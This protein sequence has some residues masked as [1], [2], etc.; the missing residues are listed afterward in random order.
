MNKSPTNLSWKVSIDRGGT[1]TDIVATSSNGEIR[2]GKVLSQDKSGGLAEISGV[3]QLLG[4]EPVDQLQLGTTIGTNAILER[5]G[6]RVGILTN[7][8]LGGIFQV[9][10]QT[11]PDIFSLRYNKSAPIY[12]AI[13]E[14]SA[15]QNVLG[16]W[17]GPLNETEVKG[18]LQKLR[19][20]Q[21]EVLL[22]HFIHSL[23][24]PTLEE[25]VAMIAKDCGFSQVIC[26]HELGV[27]Q[28]LQR[29]QTALVDGYVGP[30]IQSYCQK[31]KE[32]IKSPVYLMQ[33][34]GGLCSIEMFRGKDSL[35]SGPAGGVIG[36]IHEAKRLGIQKIIGFDM[37]GTSTDVFHFSGSIERSFEQEVAGLKLWIPML[38]IHTV[39]SGGG[40]LL[41]YSGERPQ[42]G[43]ESSSSFPGPACYGRGGPLSLTDCS[44]AQGK[45]HPCFFPDVFGDDYNLPLQLDRTNQS[46]DFLKEKV[47]KNQMTTTELAA[48]FA[49]V[50]VEKMALAIEEITTKKGRD[51]KDHTLFCYGG[52]GGQYACEVAER[53]SLNKVAFHPL[54][55]VLSA[56]GIGQA[57]L[58]KETQYNIEGPLSH[59]SNCDVE[60]VF[61]EEKRK[62]TLQFERE[63]IS[64]TINWEFQLRLKYKGSLSI[65]EL[66]Y[67]DLKSLSKQFHKQHQKEFG[68]HSINREIIVDSAIL[69]GIIEGPKL[70]DQN[71]K[72]DL[73]P[74]NQKIPKKISVF[75][76][77]K[78]SEVPVLNYAQIQEKEEVVGP[79]VVVLST[80]S[81][82]IRSGWRGKKQK[83]IFVL[84]RFQSEVQKV[85]VQKELSGLSLE[86]LN[87]RFTSVAKHMG[88]RLQKTAASINI[89]DRLDFSCALFDAI[90]RLIT[91]APHI[92]VHLGS[93]Q[94]SVEAILNKQNQFSPGDCFITNNPYNG[95]THLPDITV[96]SPCFVKG[97]KKPAFFVASRGHHADIGGPVPGSMPAESSSILDEGVLF[98]GE[99]I[100]SGNSFHSDLVRK[101]LGSGAY[102]ARNIEQ[103][104]ADLE[105]QIAA[106]TV[107]IELLQDMA[108]EWGIELLHQYSN[109]IQEESRLLAAQAFKQLAPNKVESC[110]D[111]GQKVCLHLN[112]DKGTLILDFSGSS[113]QFNHNFNIPT[114]VTKACV[115]YAIRLLI[116]KEI[117]LND[118]CTRNVRLLIP[119]GS[120]LDPVFPAPV[121]A[122]N[123]ETSQRVVECLL[124]SFNLM[125]ESQGTMNNISFGNE[126][127]QYYETLGGGMGATNFGKGADATH[128]HMTNSKLTDVEILEQ[129]YP[130][131]VLSTGLRRNSAGEGL[132]SGGEGMERIYLFLEEMEL[133][134]ITSSRR[135]APR[136][137]A[138]G[139]CGKIGENILIRDG[140]Q[141]NL[142]SSCVIRVQKNDKLIIR[143]P[144][145]GGFGEKT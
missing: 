70:E 62:L 30:L 109:K 54:S 9:K 145:G 106:N 44:L 14:I 143:T 65:I 85:S 95:G 105:A 99:K 88:N 43:P 40:S 10:D 8:G 2:V 67:N 97:E 129:N 31:L 26:S 18:Q 48:Q 126:Q 58:I 37:G 130:V 93:M 72:W 32:Q 76:Q 120:F 45:I 104:L 82:Y 134:L 73:P 17:E 84:E 138:G 90:G 7:Q 34:N 96:V 118:G 111:F 141:K 20:Q 49:R 114:A 89:R 35:L 16:Y 63:L 136:G 41:S 107:G 140:V 3:K 12:H 6:A 91:N 113:N 137:L 87:N 124:R 4:D 110:F 61:G 56:W 92:P 121:A 28:F 117:P 101:M 29:G 119:P 11:R 115:L 15:R 24:H 103:N 144:G 46:F 100:V 71:F 23:H 108:K 59:L 47:G 79:K 80:T 60:K 57:P 33:S 128:S 42:V 51:I 52:A 142:G 27:P 13:A 21:V 19:D 39:A 78:W 132:Y 50:A 55:S 94:G 131:R 86:L 75:D 135:V 38:D 102:P 1:F 74:V 68:H 116:G 123:V 66:G 139:E 122:G 69:R 133:S 127:V 53:L 77:D 125:A 81:F 22:I 98:D 25:Q 112:V 5:T 83:G 36:C 64:G